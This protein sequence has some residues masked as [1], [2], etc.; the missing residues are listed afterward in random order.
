MR[1]KVV[2]AALALV[3]AVLAVTSFV[4]PAPAL[5]APGGSAMFLLLLVTGPVAAAYPAVML[6]R[7]AAEP[8]T[9][10]WP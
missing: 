2:A 6:S 8:R 9:H 4:L 7:R 3:P 1:D 10:S 5:S